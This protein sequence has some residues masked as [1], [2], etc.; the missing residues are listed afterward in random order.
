MIAHGMPARRA[1]ARLASLALA[2]P[3]LALGCGDAEPVRL[4]GGTLRATLDE[5]LVEPQSVSVPP[6]RLRLV[7]TNEGRLSHNLRVI[8][9]S[10]EPGDQPRTLGGTATA[11]PGETVEGTVTLRPGRYELVCALANHDDLGQWGTLVVER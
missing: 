11:L 3:A 1:R 6:G 8:V 5:Y 10:E 2:A 9:P 7:A 4:A